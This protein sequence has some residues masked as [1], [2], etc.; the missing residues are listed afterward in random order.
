MKLQK[1][2]SCLL[3]T[4][5]TTFSLNAQ[6]YDYGSR[7]TKGNLSSSI[8]EA[9]GMA[10]SYKHS[11][12]FWVHNDGGSSNNEIYLY[13]YDSET[14]TK[15]VTINN[16]ENRDWEDMASFEYGGT[17]YL[18]IGATGK[19][20]SG[21]KRRQIIIVEEPGS[22][23]T[24][25]KHKRF[26]LKDPGSGLEDIEA[27]AVAPLA[28]KVIMLGKDGNINTGKSRIYSFD[29]NMNNTTTV[30]LDLGQPSIKTDEMVLRVTGMDI[31][32]D[33]KRIIIIGYKNNTG[34]NDLHEYTVNNGQSIKDALHDNTP[35]K[36]DLETNKGYQYESVCYDEEGKDIYY[37]YETNGARVYKFSAIENN[38]NPLPSDYFFD[39]ESLTDWTSS[40]SISLDNDRE[41]GDKS[42]KGNSFSSSVEYKKEITNGKTTGVTHNNGKL[43]FWYKANDAVSQNKSDQIRVEIRSVGGDDN[44]EYQWTLTNVV[45]GWKQ[46]TLDLDDNAKTGTVDLSNINYFRIYNSYGS[47]GRTTF[48]DAISFE[49]DA[50]SIPAII[51]NC[52]STSGWSSENGSVILSGTRQEGDHSVKMEGTNVLEFKKEFSGISTG[53][54]LSN[55]ILKLDYYASED[56]DDVH[57]EIS[58]TAGSN[59]D[60]EDL[61]WVQ[62]A[63]EGWN[64]INI[65]LNDPNVIG[66]GNINLNSIKSFRIFNTTE[67]GNNRTTRVDHIRIESS[68]SNPIPVQNDIVGKLITGYQGWFGADGDGSPRNHWRHWNSSQPTANDQDFELYPDMREY[69]NTYQTGYANLGN[70]QPTTLFSSYDNQVVDKHFEWM[71]DYGIDVAALQRFGSSL[72]NTTKKAHRDGM[73]T[74]V[75]NAAQTFGRKFFVMYDIS[76]WTNF[77]SEIKTDWQNTI[78]GSLDL[79]ASPAYAK[80]N[81]KPVVCIWGFGTPNRPGN[82][83]SY[84]DVINWFKGQG[85]YVM[86]GLDKDWRQQSQNLQAFNEADMITPW[87]VGTFEYSGLNSQEFNHSWVQKI[88]DDMDYCKAEGIDYMPGAWAGFAWS[89]WNGGTVNS[90]PRMH[91]DFMWDQFYYIKSKFNEKNMPAT[92]YVAMF[93]EYDEGTAIAKAAE[94]AS[95]IP[96]DQYFLTLDADGVHCS[97][98]FYLRLT[99]D[100]AKMMKGEI[101]LTKNHPTPHVVPITTAD[102]YLDVCDS[103]YGWNTSSSNT[104]TASGTVQEGSHSVKMIGDGQDEFY[105]VYPTPYNTEVSETAGVLKFWYYVED[106]SKFN[107]SNQIE[108][109]SGG[110][111]DVNEYNWSLSGLTNGWNEISLNISDANVTGGT[112]DLGA[113]NWF[114]IYR[115]KNGSTTTRVDGIQLQNGGSSSKTAK[116]KLK[117]NAELSRINLYPNP[118][119]GFVNIDLNGYQTKNIHIRLYDITGKKIIDQEI[120][121]K[122]QSVF[123]LDVNQVSLGIHIL[124]VV[125]DGQIQRLK[126]SIK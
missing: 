124:Q 96:T 92:T 37:T 105:K 55:G 27:I 52:E 60:N 42:I 10:P 19:N 12:S 125:F 58:S 17:S 113:I 46:Y 110:A 80:Q 35:R 21:G 22:N 39:V 61:E 34:D 38:T 66:S 119:K 57:F 122:S 100:G 77:Q 7:E 101:A 62:D 72:T 107:S 79:L 106:V 121:G 64:A 112:P 94:D 53:Y 85:C 68:S 83:A 86:V 32:K 88:D 67:N 120:S 25:S 43:K 118:A 89:N 45:A 30:D 82:N 97:S 23:T 76:S 104:L 73:A 36:I 33:E 93:D 115:S 56:L 40:G 111:A 81:G 3:F 31:S 84:L 70:G 29:L 102:D 126:L 6:Q 15:T 71:R 109:G 78:D 24:V 13:N 50:P 99:G 63:S 91:G 116:S 8:P 11:N 48:L 5:A 4:V 16:E 65:P 108:L 14:I 98:D 51:D 74:K 87:H 28:N 47:F 90:K 103:S 95:M 123:R 26:V 59:V 69:T 49:S 117:N 2:L 54:S 75:R 114:R 20:S 44:N 9:S 1:I 18:A 41:I